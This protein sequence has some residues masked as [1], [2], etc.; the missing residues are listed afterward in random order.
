[1]ARTAELL[2][3][4]TSTDIDTAEKLDRIEGHITGARREAVQALRDE[5]REVEVQFDTAQETLQR[6]LGNA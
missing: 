1:M 2:A 3:I 4:I 6:L 5:L